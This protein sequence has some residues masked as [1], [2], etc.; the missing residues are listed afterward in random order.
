MAGFHVVRRLRGDALSESVRIV[1][2]KRIESK[3]SGRTVD[4]R[5]EDDIGLLSEANARGDP[6]VSPTI[7]HE[8]CPRPGVAS[9]THRVIRA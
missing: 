9:V 5:A 6:C 4:A 7:S 3:M 8:A 2:A 1:H